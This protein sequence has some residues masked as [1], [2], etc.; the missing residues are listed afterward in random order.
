MSGRDELPMLPVKGCRDDEGARGSS[1]SLRSAVQVSLP[2]PCSVAHWQCSH[3]RYLR[4]TTDAQWDNVPSSG[5]IKSSS[6]TV[7]LWKVSLVTDIMTSAEVRDVLNN[8]FQVG[9]AIQ[10]LG[11]PI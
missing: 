11:N 6:S 5:S 7:G 8:Q 4:N 10:Q 3:G 2:F 9:F 1:K